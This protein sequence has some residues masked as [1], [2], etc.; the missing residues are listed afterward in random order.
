MYS[1]PLIKFFDLCKK[2]CENFQNLRTALAN[3]FEI[4]PHPDRKM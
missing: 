2:T 3:R 4:H 1:L